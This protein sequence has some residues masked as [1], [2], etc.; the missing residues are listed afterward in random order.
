[1][2]VYR[3][4]LNECLVTFLRI[5]LG[6]ISEEAGADRTTNSIVVFSSRNDI[7]LIPVQ[8]TL[9]MTDIKTR[10]HRYSPVH[11]TQQLLPDILRPSHASSLD[12]ILVTPWIRV[13]TSFPTIPHRQ[14]RQVVT[15]WLV[16]L[17]LL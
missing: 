17:R 16:K 10:G 12:E 11:N 3:S 8:V 5:F 7:M 13:V 4:T 2:D 14:Q 1:M 9:E 6:C 15:F